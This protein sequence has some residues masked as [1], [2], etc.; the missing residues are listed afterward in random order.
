MP[1]TI[2]RD[3]R[4]P[5]GFSR[6]NALPVQLTETGPTGQ[7]WLRS[8]LVDGQTGAGSSIPNERA[9]A[10][11]GSFPLNTRRIVRWYERFVEM[12]TTSLDRWQVVGPEIHGPNISAFPQALLHLEVGPDKR[13]RLNANAGRAS[14]RYDDIGPIV[15]GQVYAMLMDVVLT[16][17]STGYIRVYR[18]GALVAQFTGATIHQASPGSYWKE[19][20]YRNA[21]INGPMTYD[22]SDMLLYA[23]ERD[24][25]L[26]DWPGPIVAP[27][28]SLVPK[29]T[30][31]SPVRDTSHVGTL[32]Y[33]VTLENPPQGYTLY[34]GLGGT[35]VSASLT[36]G[37][38]GGNTHLGALDLS[39][40]P[41]AGEVRTM[42]A[43]LHD[44]SGALITFDGFQVNVAS[45]PVE[46]PPPPPPPD[47]TDPCAE[48]RQILAETVSERNAAREGRD[49]ALDALNLVTA[50]RD[51]ARTIIDAVRAVVK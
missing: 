33:A 17:D 42:Y 49:Q 46:P 5:A 27:P 11:F 12:P 34:V 7:P 32:P 19:A 39:T 20:N 23:A 50:E 37:V 21:Q 24:D 36:I 25:Q 43:A 8:R 15:L 28:P 38:N 6:E 47:P 4:T 18:D 14:T 30:I 51:A 10:T 26:P 13:R 35:P 41:A 2:H 16:A 45:A 3:L 40:R 9:D 29:V 44:A 1:L 31:T 48:I 22:I